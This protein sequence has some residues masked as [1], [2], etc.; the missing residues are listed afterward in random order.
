M[1]RND[2]LTAEKI[3]AQAKAFGADLAGIAWVKDLKDLPWLWLSV[4]MRAEG[5]L[6]TFST[7]PFERSF[8]LKSKERPTD[9]H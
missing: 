8:K 2:R 6:F 1:T 9:R 5:A 3:I 7:S 4:I